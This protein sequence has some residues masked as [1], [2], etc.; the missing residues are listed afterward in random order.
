MSFLTTPIKDF[1]YLPS[2][3]ARNIAVQN[4]SYGREDVE[5]WMTNAFRTVTAAA[6]FFTNRLLVQKHENQWHYVLAPIAAGC[7]Q[8]ALNPYS[9]Y[10]S[11]GYLGVSLGVEY[12]IKG[13]VEQH[14]FFLATGS[15]GLVG[16][17][18][19]LYRAKKYK[20]FCAHHFPEGIPDGILDIPFHNWAQRFVVWKYDS[21][22]ETA[23][24]DANPLGSTR[25]N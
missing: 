19:A 8:Y 12:L 17:I 14:T 9:L 5:E 22:K 15:F 11:S 1:V 25:E 20:E 24:K 13:F 23:T 3:V 7:F 21:S 16:G 18:I 6:F 10:I 2:L 4:K